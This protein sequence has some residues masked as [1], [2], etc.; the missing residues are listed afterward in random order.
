MGKRKNEQLMVAL[1]KYYITF[2]I[3]LGCIF[4]G[5]YFVLGITLSK[6]I[7]ENKNVPVYSL[8]NDEYSDYKDIN[9]AELKS[10]GGYLEVLDSNKKVIYTD[11]K[12]PNNIKASY[13][14][15][16]FE[17]TISM[18]NKESRF[19]VIC[20]TINKSD[21]EH[22]IVLIM[23]P[24]D[25]LT[26][27]LHLNSVP[28]KVG[29]PL[30]KLYAKVIAAAIML[31]LISIII[32]SIWTAK[33]IKRPLKKIDEALGKVI[34]GDYEEKLVIKGQK[35][36]IVISDTINFLIDKLKYSREENAKLEQSKTR[37]L[38][39]LSHDIKT[40]ITTIR[41]FSAALYEG[42]IEEEE[43]KERYYKTIYNKAEHVGEL[44]DDLFEFVKMD[45]TQYVLKLQKIDICEFIRQ[46]IVNYYD[47]LEE[48]NFELI[49]KIPEEAINLK[50]DAKLFKRVI[51]NLIQNS[52][53]Y[54]PIGTKL[55]VEVKEFK[56]YVI[57]EIADSG[58][59]IKSEIQ[60]KVFDPFVRGDES[61]SSDG[62]GLG[63][64]IA[65]KI[66]ENHGGEIELFSNRKDDS[67]V[68]SIRMY[69]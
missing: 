58:I 10:I 66:V 45:S 33:K 43:K 7:E 4:I 47:E 11:G 31:F 44:V 26:L 24:Q 68:F 29:K 3:I 16:E 42:L 17:D 56:R 49:V 32:Y 5:S 65:K 38:M 6:Y 61:R 37:M 53:K 23:I 36:F 34:E 28:Y 20:K 30:Y 52:I 60:D 41:G 35:E 13:T 62:S 1:F 9:T 67:T 55:R 40:P 2:V 64:A 51:S 8:I 27:N 14:N 22:Y 48:K 25:K 69:K 19:N 59:G 46:V 18:G 15:K 21:E 54:N 12:V 39:D 57:I 63:L 50:I